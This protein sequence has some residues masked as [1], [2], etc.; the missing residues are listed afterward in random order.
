MLITY[1]Q[2]FFLSQQSLTSVTNKPIYIE[3]IRSY[4]VYSCRIIYVYFPVVAMF[5]ARSVAT[6]QSH[7]TSIDCLFFHNDIDIFIFLNWKSQLDV[8]I[9]VLS[10]VERRTNLYIV[11]YYIYDGFWTGISNRRNRK[12]NRLLIKNFGNWSSLGP[13]KILPFPIPTNLVLIPFRK[14]H[15]V[16]GEDSTYMPV[17]DFFQ[18]SKI[19]INVS[20]INTTVQTDSSL[21]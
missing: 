10:Q 20:E 16:F 13:R 19:S 21:A 1:V 11:Y 15:S 5:T 3:F 6:K 8:L 2:Y 4:L 18:W 7:L 17:H 12:T 9:M 14:N